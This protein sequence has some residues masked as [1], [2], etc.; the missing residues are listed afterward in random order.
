MDGVVHATYV[1]ARMHYTVTRLL[2]SGL[3]TDEEEQA[4]LEAQK[5]NARHYA[6]GWA[7]ID[8]NAQWTPAGKAALTAARAYMDEYVRATGSQHFGR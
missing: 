6:D 7:V 2:D 3:L 5:R 4:A 1:I 8:T